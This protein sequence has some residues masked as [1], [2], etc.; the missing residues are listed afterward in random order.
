[1]E[2]TFGELIKKQRIDKGLTQEEMAKKFNVSQTYWSLIEAD[3]KKPFKL[4]YKIC[5]ELGISFQY[6][7]SIK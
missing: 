7:D 2:L 6:L 4:C 3:I 1:M 5:K